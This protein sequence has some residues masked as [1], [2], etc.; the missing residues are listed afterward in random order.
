MKF[1]TSKPFNWMLAPAR[2]G[3]RPEGPFKPV[4]GQIKFFNPKYSNAYF[5]SNI[6]S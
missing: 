1:A 4:K 6:V 3:A 5:E 2:L